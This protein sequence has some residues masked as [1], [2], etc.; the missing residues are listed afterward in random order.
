MGLWQREGRGVEELML[1]P[2]THHRGRMAAPKPSGLG[3]RGGGTGG[4]H[5]AARSSPGCIAEP[6]PSPVNVRLAEV[7]TRQQIK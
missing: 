6:G 7:G 3:L 1:G 2:G 4:D 5:P